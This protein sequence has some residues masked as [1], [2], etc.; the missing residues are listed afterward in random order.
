MAESIALAVLENLVHMTRQDFPRGYVCV[1]AV[2]PAGMTM[3][4]EKDLRKHPALEGL[5]SEQLGDWWLDS[6]TSTV[7]QVPSFVIAGEHNFL[8]NPVHPE[9][10][11]I[12]V[13]PPAIFH[14]DERLFENPR[15]EGRG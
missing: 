11:R 3:I 1:A 8:L 6:R 10:A 12:Q 7:L 5:S 14:F 13:E 2:L 9:F 4:S 15:L